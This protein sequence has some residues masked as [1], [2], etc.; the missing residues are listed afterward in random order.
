LTGSFLFFLWVYLDLSLVKLN[1]NIDVIDNKKNKHNE[2][3]VGKA[4]SIGLWLSSG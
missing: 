4:G 3:D 2:Q 1:F